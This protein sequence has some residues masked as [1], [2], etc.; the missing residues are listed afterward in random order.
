MHPHGV[1][2]DKDFEG[3]AYDDGSTAKLKK[4]D[5]VPPGE[6]HTYTWQVPERAGPGPN[7][8]SSI[9]CLYHS[10][11]D[12]PK[13]VMSGLVGVIIVTRRGIAGP[14]GKPKD[15]DHE[16]VNLFMIF[17]ENAS[18]YLDQNINIYTPATQRA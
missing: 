5:V 4:G 13:D 1:L 6:T 2:Y 11:A 17:D 14:E 12:E 10:H 18:W 9:V 3:S 8:P 15:V 7:D 16:F